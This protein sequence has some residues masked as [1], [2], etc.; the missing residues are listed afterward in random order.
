MLSFESES[1]ISGTRL[2]MNNG[3]VQ[4]LGAVV[5]FEVGRWEGGSGRWVV[6]SG[7]WVVGGISTEGI[8]TV[9]N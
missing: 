4:E 9:G 1:E 3:R 6:G 7:K 5:F 2:L 8:S